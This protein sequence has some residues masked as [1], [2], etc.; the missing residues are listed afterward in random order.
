VSKGLTDGKL[1]RK[2][3]VLTTRRHNRS[4]SEGNVDDNVD[5]NEK[6]ANKKDARKSVG[7]ITG[8]FFLILL[9]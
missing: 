6:R 8:I 9:F 5:K 2:S 7:F 3:D 4:A 1:H